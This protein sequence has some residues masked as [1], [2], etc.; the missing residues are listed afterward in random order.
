MDLMLMRAELEAQYEDKLSRSQRYTASL[1]EER[2]N[3]CENKDITIQI[4]TA[5]SVAT[6]QL[7]ALHS[8]Q[9]ERIIQEH[10]T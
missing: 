4:E 7:Q 9:L 2:E 8:T 10:K 3:H 1:I 6:Q 5:V